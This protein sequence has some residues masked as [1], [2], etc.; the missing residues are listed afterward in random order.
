MLMRPQFFSLMIGAVLLL[1]GAG[2]VLSQTTNSIAIAN[3]SFEA[4]SVTAGSYAVETPTSWSVV[5][6]SAGVVAIVH[7]AAGD[8]RFSLY[9]PP[10][11][12]GT[13][14]CQIYSTAGNDTGTVYQDL[15]SANKYQAGVTYTLTAN[16]GWEQ[17]HNPPNS[18]LVFFN[19]SLVPIASNSISASG[20]TENSFVTETVTYTA[21]G[22]E[23][24][25]GDIIVGFT[26]P[27][28]ISR[29]RKEPCP[30]MRYYSAWGRRWLRGRRCNINGRRRRPVAVPTPT[31]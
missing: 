24:G 13:N 29:F 3:H 30:G 25:N 19:S 15:G 12:D 16:F 18:L 31:C 6:P 17:D 5:G 4:Q 2:T 27:G 10:G 23:G 14:F 7:P 9:P 28:P 11:L 22:T 21:T 1:A 20:L 26:T 8:T